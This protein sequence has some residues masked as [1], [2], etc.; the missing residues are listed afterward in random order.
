MIASKFGEDYYFSN[1]HY[2]S[3]GGIKQEDLDLL[4]RDFLTTIAYDVYLSESEVRKYS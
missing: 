4:E 2:S 1:K 3:V